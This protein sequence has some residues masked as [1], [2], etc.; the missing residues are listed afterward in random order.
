[1]QQQ[2]F[3]HLRTLC[4]SLHA[5]SDKMIC[6]VGPAGFWCYPGER[7]FWGQSSKKLHPAIIPILRS[8]AMHQSRNIS[9]QSPLISPISLYNVDLK[10]LAKKSK[11][12]TPLSMSALLFPVSFVP[13]PLSIL[14]GLQ[15]E[16]SSS[17]HV[18]VLRHVRLR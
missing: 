11:F 18:Q 10:L 15:A 3:H 14:V 17:F 8:W 1:M 4:V 5:F 16:K 2:A 7:V 6:L 12:H 13:P 9:Y